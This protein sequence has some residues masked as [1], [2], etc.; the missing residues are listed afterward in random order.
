[1]P[2]HEQ[3][4]FGGGIVFIAAVARGC[5]VPASLYTAQWASLRL[6]SVGSS[7]LRHS[8]PF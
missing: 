3:E 1:M 7:E 5:P 4:R 2:L 6:N 8:F